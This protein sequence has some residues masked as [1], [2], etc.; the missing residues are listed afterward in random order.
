MELSADEEEG[1]VP[2]KKHIRSGQ[3]VDPSGNK[4][5]SSQLEGGFEQ[6]KHAD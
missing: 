4:A 6:V 3:V 2:A 1:D 5:R